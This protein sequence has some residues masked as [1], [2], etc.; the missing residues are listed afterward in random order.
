MDSLSSFE[1]CTVITV[2]HLFPHKLTRK[3]TFISLV[4]NHLLK[5]ALF[6]GY[7]LALFRTLSNTLAA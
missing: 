5:Q 1:L 2:C 7:S 4:P 6:L 3:G